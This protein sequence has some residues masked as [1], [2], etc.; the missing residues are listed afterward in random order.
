MN[1][2]RGAVEASDAETHAERRRVDEPNGRTE[3]VG[4]FVSFEY[5]A[6]FDRR[7]VQ[8]VA[9]SARSTFEGM[10][11]LRLKVFTVD[12]ERRRA[13]NFYV[14]ESREAAR[15]FFTPELIE[16][17]TGLYGVPPKIEFVDI[18]TLVDNANVSVGV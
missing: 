18:A 13:V 2:G 5:D 12:E 8:G 6:D 10:A 7:R 3:M 9:D 15:R 16:R 4:V 17:V 14:W 11:E 1:A